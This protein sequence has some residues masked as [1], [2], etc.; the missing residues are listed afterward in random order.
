MSLLVTDGFFLGNAREFFLEE[1]SEEEGR[2]G[3]E[4]CNIAFAADCEVEEIRQ[5][6]WFQCAVSSQL[7]QLHFQKEKRI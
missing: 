6:R 2:E 1:G 7:Q 3:V 4:G 5:Y